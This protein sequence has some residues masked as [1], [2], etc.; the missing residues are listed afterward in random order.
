M[1]KFLF[2]VSATFFIYT[3][4]AQ[5]S[6][7]IENG[8]IRQLA[9]YRKTTISNIHYTLNFSIPGSRNAAIE[10]EEMLSFS[11]KKQNKI[12]LQIDFKNDSDAVHSL[13]VNG[14]SIHPDYKN[15]HIVIADNYLKQG[16]NKVQL[17]FI[18]G[19]AA[20][21]RRGDFMY[22]LLVPDHART[23]FPCFDQ[24]DLKATF[25]LALTLPKDWQ[26]ITNGALLKDSF[27][28]GDWKNYKFEISDTIPTYL[29]AFAAG[30]FKTA[31]EDFNQQK[32]T[33]LYR[34]TDSAKIAN[35]LDSIF[36]IYKRSVDFC[37]RWTGIPYPFQKY[38]MI[39]IPDFQ[40][41]GMEHPGAILFQNASLFLDKNATQ[42]Q[43]N[44][45][46]NLIAHEVA[47]QWFGDMVTMKWFN[48]VWM[49]EV[50]A[51]F[52][53]DKSTS[54]FIN[55][56]EY[57]I[58]FLTTHVPAAY[59]VDRTLG[60]NPVR[61]T[62][63]NLQNAGM[64]YGP[65]IYDKA[66]IVMRQLEMMMGAE[67]FR[68]GVDE[69]LH[70]YAY[71]NASWP[72]LI[73][74]LD[75]H[76]ELDLKQWNKVWVNEPG[77]PIIND[78]II[79]DHN[80][81]QSFYI[82]QHPEKAGS[83]KVWQQKINV[84]LFYTDSVHIIN[85]NLSDVKQAVKEAQNLQKPL[86]VLLNASG[87]GYGVFHADTMEEKY[88]DLIKDSVSRTSV[89][90]SLYENM[91]NGKGN[92]PERLM[93]FFLDRLSKEDNEL[94]LRLLTN[95]IAAC[96]WEFVSKNKRIN[97][98]A[99][100]ESYVWQAMQLQSKANNK[101]ILFDCY[102]ANFISS[103]AYDTLFAIWKNQ[104]PPKGIILNEDDYTA[105]ALSLGLRSN[106]NASIL[107]EQLKRIKNNDRIIRFKI[108]MNAASSDEKTR[109]DFFNSLS[110]KQNR[111][112]ESAIL[113]SLSYLH[114][115]LRQSTSQKYL[116]RTL[117]LLEEIQKTGDIFFS[118][119]WLKTTF[120][121][122]QDAD[123]FSIVQAFLQ[124][125]PNYN[126]VLKNKIL[127]ATDNLRR[128]QELIKE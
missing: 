120:S 97:N 98:A 40:F 23:M 22:T 30:R 18:A 112:N 108:I 45:R 113:S 81:I 72:D 60:A 55:Q 49:K 71:A 50:F 6:L 17:K 78:S 57:D 106:N 9:E 104:T 4:Y 8:I 102:A 94:I 91:L 59:N 70:K 76:T 114:H 82:V 56:K 64:L 89:Y 35:S 10:G 95:Y 38:G 39:A 14:V 5:Q 111:I 125:H 7:S 123:A 36:S 53:A 105:L 54:T 61:Q 47:H 12:P 69:Y 29:F 66:P 58:K 26:A 92:N 99:M 67:N 42:T 20:L 62:L 44:T 116:K 65:I 110:E 52:M 16:L 122:Y 77:R 41:G 85:V 107:N 88:I 48:D 79:Y 63:D 31:E 34:E 103:N 121:N 15:E 96:Y 33:L 80:K 101:K 86:F 115:P 1:R 21:N 109:N 126:E 2:F 28:G 128:A 117:E 118:D 27:T 68:K 100:L 124:S 25:S 119:G 51:N 46:S 75:K 19:D 24:P 11:Y 43:F 127:Q 83:K 93:H 32:I 87:I 13:I 74:I 73:N 84:A 90:I 37:Q 3:L